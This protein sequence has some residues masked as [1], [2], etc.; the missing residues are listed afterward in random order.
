MVDA[1]GRGRAQGD[2]LEGHVAPD[3]GVVGD[4]HHHGHGRR[5]EVDRVGEVHAVLH[6]DAHPQHADHAV[7]D[8]GRPA[9]DAGGDRGDDLAELRQQGQAQG[10]E[11]RHHVGG[12]GVDAGGGHDADV[13]RVGGG[14]RAAAAAGEHGGQAVGEQGPAGDVVEV[15]PGHGRDGLD[16][17]DVLSDEDE[18]HGDEQPQVAHVEGRGLEVGQPQDR[19]LSDG[20]EV[21]LPAQHCGGVA[22]EYA[23][24]D[25]Q[26]PDDALEQ[27]RDDQDRDD[28]DDRGHRAL[29][30]IAPGRGGQVEADEGDDRAGDDR[31]HEPVDPGRADQ[32]DDNAHH[33]QAQSHR[34]DSALRQGGLVGVEGGTAVA[35][36]AGHRSDGGKK[37]EGGAQVA[38]QAPGGDAQEQQGAHTGE[39]QRRRRVEAGQQRHQEGGAEHGDDVLDTDADGSRPGEALAGGDDLA[40]SDGPAIAVQAPATRGRRGHE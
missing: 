17:T 22:D 27:H 18:H 32:V 31:R 35:R 12:G 33:Q 7:E 16:V 9:Q 4:G 36:V 19:G 40:R 15:L 28:R 29:R 13:L 3:Q 1:D 30:D 23:D 34:D 6:P 11:R 2:A 26:A 21:D 24:E 8:R 38:G 5:V 10:A 25:R 20:V 14:A 37:C 39:E